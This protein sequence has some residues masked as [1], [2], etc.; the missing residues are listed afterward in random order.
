MRASSL[1]DVVQQKLATFDALEPEFA[2]CFAFVEAVHGQ[3]RFPRLNVADVVRY[4]HACYICECKDRLLGVPQTIRRYRGDEALAR[5]GRWQAGDSTSVVALL[6]ER[7]DG[8]PF[9]QITAEMAAAQS[10]PDQAAMAAR[11][12]HGRLVLLTRTMN[13][14]RLLDAIFTPTDAKLL[15]QVRE[16]AAKLDHTPEQIASALA[17]FASPLYAYMAHHAL[18]QR[19]M[20][21]MNIVGVGALMRPA[22]LP[23]DRT[24]R[25]LPSTEPPGPFAEIPIPAYTELTSPLHN[26]LRHHRFVDRPDTPADIARSTTIHVEEVREA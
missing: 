5:L 14:T 22:D 21:V 25:V 23:G 8:H 2:A 13:L 10:Q 12:A 3:R 4:L 6:E 9:A 16:A 15:R 17:A 19:N 11:L 1:P 26:N 18:A 7:L 20:R 24:W